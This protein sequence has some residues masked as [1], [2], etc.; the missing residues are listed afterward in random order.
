MLISPPSL[1][2]GADRPRV[3]VR[4]AEVSYTLGE[5][6]VAL[7]ERCG[8][9][10]EPWQ[11]AGLDL[12]L[13]VRPDG[14]WA[15]F[16]YAEICARQNGKTGAAA[17]RALAGL[18]LLEE[19]LI[20]W[21]AHEYKTAMEAFRL[22]RD[23]LGQIGRRVV[24]NRRDNLIDVGKIRIKILATN[25]EEGFERLD[26]GARLRFVARSKGSGR[27]FTA[28]CMIIDEAF[29]YSRDQ[30]SALM[31]TLSAVP[32]PQLVYASSPPLDSDSGEPLFALRERA[33]RGDTTGLGYRDWGLAGDLGEIERM[34][35]EERRAYLD[36][37]ELWCRT[38]PALGRGR[39]TNES[40]ERNRRSMADLDFAREVLGIWP[41]PPGEGGVIRA[42]TW[43]ALT[44]PGSEIVGQCV[45]AVDANPE[46][47]RCA[48]AA[49]GRNASG[50]AHLEVVE[51]R[52]GL[53]WVLA[54]A[55]ELDEAHR[56]LTWLIDPAGPA[57]PLI[58]EFEDAKLPVQLVTGR[59]WAQCCGAFY[60]AVHSAEQVLV[61]LGDPVLGGAVASAKKRDV[62]DGAWAWGRRNS[63]ANIAPLCAATL[64]L[65]GVAQVYDVLES[66]W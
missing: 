39:F 5:P 40:I 52:P 7:A 21:S 13:S 24:E 29:A 43:D 33:E 41:V 53:D 30:Q 64:A 58:A 56:P 11:A 12:M 18:L 22:V 66:A 57:G 35:P 31:P 4:P 28:D 44:D 49:G 59:E 10:L 45:F 34:P 2:L 20:I 61:H 26:T 42:K 62:G 47:S 54:R 48:I 55:K 23:L 65:H 38:N 46:R 50:L 37:R 16:E 63:E 60:D 27:G 32:N 6:A 17:I 25:G 19:K 51:Q 1:L 9:V 3:E 8:F 15:C 14:R 36:D